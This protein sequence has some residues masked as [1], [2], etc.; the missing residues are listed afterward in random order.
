MKKLSLLVFSLFFLIRCAAYKQ[1]EPQPK[2]SPLES[3]FI[4]LKNDKK[5]FDL[6]A[7]KKYYIEFPPAMG[8]NYYLVLNIDQKEDIHSYLTDTFD[9]GEGRI[10]EIPDKS[11]RPDKQSVY[12]VDNSVQKLYWVVDLVKRDMQLHMTYRY[13]EQWRF[14]FE[15][16]HDSFEKIFTQNK[17]DSS[18]FARLGSPLDRSNL[19]LAALI[20]ELQTKTTAL[21]QLKKELASIEAIFPPQIV[22]TTDRAYQT[23]VRFSEKLDQELQF[24]ADFLLAARVFQAAEAPVPEFVKAIGSFITLFKNEAHYPRTIY[25]QAQEAA[26]GKIPQVV[27][28]Y[29]AQLQAKRDV[30][31]IT[32]PLDHVQTMLQSGQLTATPA[33]TQLIQF[34]HAYNTKAKSIRSAK[35]TYESIKQEVNSN[36]SMPSNTYF[37]SILT[38]LSKIKYRLPRENRNE[39]GSFNS[40]ACVTLQNKQL[41]ALRSNIDRTLQNYRQ[42]DN[43]IP[44]INAYKQQKNYSAMLG[45]IKKNSQLPFLK[46]AYKKLDALSLKEQKQRITRALKTNHWANAENALRRLKNDGNF[47]N[48]SKSI[49]KRNQL[50]AALNDSLFN[51]VSR[52]SLQRARRFVTAHISATDSVEQAYQNPVFLPLYEPGYSV[53]GKSDLQKRNQKLYKQL[54]ALRDM[55]FPQKA[56]SRLYSEFIQHPDANGVLKARAVVIHGKHYKGADKQIKKRV[57]ECDP[58]ASKWIVKAKSYR[59]VFALPVTDHPGG[60]N[61][62]VFRLNI[63]IPGK[64]KFPV[65]D[66]NIKLPKAVAKNAAKA[67]WYTKI[68]LNKKPVKNE[69]RYTVTAP[70]AANNYEFQITPVRMLAGQDNILEVHFKH[71]SFKAFPISVMAQKPIIKKH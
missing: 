7:E 42:A 19:N 31:E 2:I 9:D 16:R 38:R 26:S 3:D 12:P 21:K 32:F 69:G 53:L 35:Q 5:Y 27:R 30:A 43:L 25:F 15:T 13:V 46:Q 56:I 70:T 34:V 24:Q 22:N 58:W 40:Y 29:T 54:A 36:T 52:L 64:A 68:L 33:F 6:D 48:P 66:L 71:K 8:A 55:E 65:Y 63:R 51:R 60:T 39:Y 11:D 47:L 1:L 4:E 18:A 10:V 23:Y 45:L 41:R 50:A 17:A 20:S 61:E 59:K 62:Y 44:Q 49:P 67:Q 57:G 28:Y 37:G 14:R